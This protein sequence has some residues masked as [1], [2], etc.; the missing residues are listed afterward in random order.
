[1]E[2]PELW[3]ASDN[4]KDCNPS[5][6]K[7]TRCLTDTQMPKTFTVIKGKVI[8]LFHILSRLL[9]TF[10]IKL[11]TYKVDYNGNHEYSRLTRTEKMYLLLE[12]PISLGNPLK[13]QWCSPCHL[14]ESYNCLLGLPKQIEPMRWGLEGKPNQNTTLKPLPVLRVMHLVI[15]K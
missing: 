12:G 13:L 2:N 11:C 15:S 7:I 14:R 5:S 6:W 10:Y 3:L 1:M 4:M 9:Y 8:N